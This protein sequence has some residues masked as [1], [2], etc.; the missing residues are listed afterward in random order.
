MG[1]WWYHPNSS[2]TAA[3]LHCNASLSINVAVCQAGD[4]SS[5]VKMK[6]NKI[7]ALRVF[8]SVFET[9]ADLAGLSFMNQFHSALFNKCTNRCRSV[10]I[11][12]CGNTALCRMS[13]LLCRSLANP[14]AKISFAFP[15][16]NLHSLSNRFREFHIQVYSSFFLSS[17][18]H[19][20]LLFLPHKSIIF[21]C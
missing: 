18:I 13:F 4:D 3:G 10:Y 8:Y 5:A 11:C 19:S 21:S 12:I 9:A 14:W 6:L 15:R 17:S 20:F 16:N 7:M 1:S 2:N